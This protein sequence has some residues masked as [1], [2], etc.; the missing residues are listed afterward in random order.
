MGPLRIIKGGLRLDTKAAV[1][2]GIIM[3]GAMIADLTLDGGSG[4]M[5]LARKFIDLVE[6]VSFWR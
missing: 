2:L 1:W 3:G 5:F 4:M 6:W